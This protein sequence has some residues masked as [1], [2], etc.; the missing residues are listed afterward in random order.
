MPSTPEDF[1]SQRPHSMHQVGSAPA[2]SRLS[3]R[4]RD[5]ASPHLQTVLDLSPHRFQR[6]YPLY[7]WH[8]AVLTG[9]VASSA[10]L[11]AGHVLLAALVGALAL[12][13]LTLSFPWIAA[14]ILFLAVAVNWTVEEWP[15]SPTK[16]SSAYL[17][18]AVAAALLVRRRLPRVHWMHF[19]VLAF[20]LWSLATALNG[21]YSYFAEPYSVT[22][23]G[24]GVTVL[25]LH[26][27]FRGTRGLTFMAGLW[28]LALSIGCAIVL[29]MSA[30]DDGWAVDPVAGD[31]ND[32]AILALMGFFLGLGLV[33]DRLL[34][35]PMR[36]LFTVCL[37]VCLAVIV[38]SISRGAW[39]ALALGLLVQVV[40]RRAERGPI[41]GSVMVIGVV[42]ALT[43]PTYLPTVLQ[44]WAQKSSVA[45]HN[46]QS[47]FDAWIVALNEFVQ[48]PVT[49]TG[50]AT[51]PLP[52]FDAM[53]LSPGMLVLGY[54]HNTYL[55]VLYGTGLV[56][57][58]LFAV[59]LGYTVVVAYRAPSHVPDGLH[60]GAAT[61]LLPTTV[62]VCFASFTVT[63][64]MY[65]PF[66]ILVA[67]AITVCPEYVR[68]EVRSLQGRRAATSSL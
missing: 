21:G 46:V 10:L 68:D 67:L 15:V 58:A 25:S 32:F 24:W 39:T 33:R 9:F 31:V 19:L 36:L 28:V 52:Y 50:I 49:G 66:W 23:I 29:V 27:I 55:E 59:I 4:W 16:A 2:G 38:G 56:G 64:I 1:T 40:L 65:A 17:V 7:P 54:V 44:A 3:R 37:L 62:A 8:I 13:T 18:L 34:R 22:I 43:A 35:W 30:L 12:V 5:R 48:R 26:Q 20:G 42:A 61:Y 41:L 53:S 47:R 6:L 60:R 14:F 63:Q 51:L 45:D 57:A 11:L